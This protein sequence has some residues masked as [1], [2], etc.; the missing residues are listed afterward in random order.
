MEVVERKA[1]GQS[2]RE[3]AESCPRMRFLYRRR[4]G[5]EGVVE[6]RDVKLDVAGKVLQERAVELR[7]AGGTGREG[8][9]EGGVGGEGGAAFGV[10]LFLPILSVGFMI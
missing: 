5:E 1:E 9:Y 4:R 7:L 2:S 8:V 6:G 3:P 10:Q